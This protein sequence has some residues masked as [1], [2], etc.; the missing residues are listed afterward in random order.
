MVQQ[1][2][3]AGLGQGRQMFRMNC[4]GLAGYSWFPHSRCRDFSLARHALFLRVLGFSGLP[5]MVG[6]SRL[7]LL[8][9]AIQLLQYGCLYGLSCGILCPHFVQRIGFFSF[10]ACLRLAYSSGDMPIIVLA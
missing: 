7:R 3:E 9:S 6:L 5:T 1:A 4:V 2:G 8:Y 10:R